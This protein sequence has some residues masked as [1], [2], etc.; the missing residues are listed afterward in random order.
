MDVALGTGLPGSDDRDSA[1]ESVEAVV[2]AVVAVVA[3][4]LLGSSPILHEPLSCHFFLVQIQS[5]KG[6]Y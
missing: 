3:V 2:V 6:Y 5:T 1:A 4:S